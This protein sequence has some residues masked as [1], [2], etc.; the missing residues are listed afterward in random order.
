M[1]IASYFVD[2]THF[3]LVTTRNLAPTF[4][5]QAAHHK[6]TLRKGLRRGDE[7][8]TIVAVCSWV[9]ALM[10]IPLIS[11]HTGGRGYMMI[12]HR[13]WWLELR[14]GLESAL[15]RVTG[16]LG[17]PHIRFS[18]VLKPQLSGFLRFFRLARV[19]VKFLDFGGC[20]KWIFDSTF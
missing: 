14:K 9:T 4:I 16:S 11:R 7:T 3:Q 5:S 13:H 17:G 20:K 1:R 10:W 18:Q 19:C 6:I 2:T 15:S 8:S 12:H